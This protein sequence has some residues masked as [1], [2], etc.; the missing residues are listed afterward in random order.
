MDFAPVKEQMDKLSRGTVDIISGEEL[1]KKLERSRS[2]GKP[3]RIK[4]GVDPTSPDIHLGHTVVLGK[5]R[6]FQDLG[7][8][9]VLII[10]DYTA[11]V[12]DPSGRNKTRPELQS[13]DI[14]TNAGTYLDQVAK[15]LDSD[16][17]EIVRNSEW[18]SRMS[19]LDVLDLARRM[20]V[21]RL[22][23][24][25]DFSSRY[26]SGAP[27]SMHE[28]MYPLMQGWDSVEVRSDVELGGTDQLFNLLVGR[29]FQRSEGQEAQCALTVPLLVGLD[30]KEKMSKSYGNYVGVTDE[31]ADMFGK[32]M[33]IPDELT[34][35]YF[36]LLTAVPMPDVEAA[37][38]DPFSAKKMLAETITA[39]YHDNEK[40]RAGRSEFERVFSKHELPSDM[41]E[42]RF[43]RSD[44][45][46]GRILPAA[47]VTRAGL[48]PSNSEARRLV[49]QGAVSIDGEKIS[50]SPEG[51][52]IADGQILKVGKR[53]FAKIRLES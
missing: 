11:R 19:F 30:G 33:S 41:P 21:A 39:A 29:D 7:H 34:K 18:F 48:A 20:T 45:N 47:L 52:E 25:D 49:K 50:D 35:L 22:L 12:G 44:L 8:Q 9:A 38:K 13:S 23:E 27:I 5:L 46:N 16:R 26:A 32:L 40:A 10:G 4:L 36:E 2:E 24:R 3:L 31:P 17:L 15:V 51:V 42:A 37:L 6:A 43:T 28:M 53:R 1:E 14:E